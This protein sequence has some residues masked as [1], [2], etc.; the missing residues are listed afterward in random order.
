MKTPGHILA[1][2]LYRPGLW[3]EA[4]DAARAKWE[5]TAAAFLEACADTRPKSAVWIV[6]ASGSNM[7]VAS[8]AIQ[9]VWFGDDNWHLELKTGWYTRISEQ[10]AQRAV[11]AI[12]GTWPPPSIEVPKP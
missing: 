6:N 12:G 7:C 10:G 5:S 3:I 1:E 8:G 11:E 2:L 9:R 4:E